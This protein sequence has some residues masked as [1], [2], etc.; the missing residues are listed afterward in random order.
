MIT[1]RTDRFEAALGTLYI[2]RK[3]D[4]FIRSSEGRPSNIKCQKKRVVIEKQRISQIR[5][6]GNSPVPDV[7][8]GPFAY[9]FEDPNR[10]FTLT[11]LA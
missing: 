10:T 3:I 8:L 1:G 11:E 6:I 4:C 5:T 9:V 7:N 2:V